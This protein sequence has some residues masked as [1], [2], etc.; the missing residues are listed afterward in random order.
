M[1]A[2]NETAILCRDIRRANL[3]FLVTGL[4]LGASITLIFC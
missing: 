3:L 2:K 4:V 1:N